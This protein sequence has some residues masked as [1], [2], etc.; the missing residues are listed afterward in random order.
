MIR[1]LNLA[2]AATLACVSAACPLV[3]ESQTPQQTI[4]HLTGK[5][6]CI[7]HDSSKKTWR[8]TTT[9]TMYGPWLRLDARY[10]AQNGQPAGSAIKL[11]G[12]DS[13]A[14]RWIVTSVD[15]SGGYYVMYST[16]PSFDGSKWIDGYPVDKG[17]ASIKVTTP[18]E[19][20]FDAAK[21][22]GHGHIVRS[23]TVCG[24]I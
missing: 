12:Y 7:T 21:P 10:P 22:D 18:N 6:I 15:D 4:E 17:T 23:H 14:R 8:A 19:Y 2:A 5:W 9:D 1:A 11:L 20:T 16:S 13:A 3:C 24:R